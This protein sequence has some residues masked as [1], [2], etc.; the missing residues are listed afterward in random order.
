MELLIHMFLFFD[1]FKYANGIKKVDAGVGA[2]QAF[3]ILNQLSLL[4]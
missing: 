2:S 3:L 4:M 1:Y